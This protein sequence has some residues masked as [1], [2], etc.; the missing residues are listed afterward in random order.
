MV[1]VRNIQ[2]TPSVSLAQLLFLFL[3]FF[4][5]FFTASLLQWVVLLLHQTPKLLV[6]RRW[7]NSTS[8]RCS[9]KDRVNDADDKPRRFAFQRRQNAVQ[10]GEEVVTG[11]AKR[12]PCQGCAYAGYF[13]FLSCSCMNEETKKR[14]SSF[15]ENK[16][17]C[18]L[19]RKLSL[20]Q[21][22]EQLIW[23]S[24]AYAGYFP[25][26]SWNCTNEEA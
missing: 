23:S 25:L 7:A 2:N 18:I 21:Q 20:G 10:F 1:P 9:H 5:S 17:L 24:C 4:F 22:K 15:K 13:R 14:A 26:L 6:T 11:A 3:F 12:T 8:F 19:A 16:T